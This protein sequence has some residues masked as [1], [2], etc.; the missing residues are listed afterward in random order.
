MR[1]RNVL[2]LPVDRSRHAERPH[3]LVPDAVQQRRAYICDLALMGAEAGELGDVF[4]EYAAGR[5]GT[6]WLCRNLLTTVRRHRS[7]ATTS[8]RRSD[9]LSNLWSDVRYALRTFRRNPGFAAAAIA[10]IALGVG[11]NTG[12]F[13]ILDAVALQPVPGSNSNELVSVYQQFRGV[14]ERRVHGSRSIHRGAAVPARR[15]GG[16]EPPAHPESVDRRR[17]DHTAI[18]VTPTPPR[19]AKAQPSLNGTSASYGLASAKAD[20]PLPAAQGIQ[21]ESGCL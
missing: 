4:E 6:L 13:S 18:R 7:P 5:R 16:G 8:E 20:V 12:I 1:A 3:D 14:T 10:P 19:N 2:P 17:N 11:I 15:C 21:Q 9:M